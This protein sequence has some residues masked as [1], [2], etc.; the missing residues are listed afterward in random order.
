MY[1]TV[2]TGYQPPIG[3]RY[4]I[5]EELFIPE[6]SLY[7]SQK[8]T[9]SN[10]KSLQHLKS[11]VVTN[12]NYTDIL[13]NL[14]VTSFVLTGNSDKLNKPTTQNAPKGMQKST[15][16][17]KKW[18]LFGAYYVVN[19]NPE[20]YI[21]VSTPYGDQPLA[22]IRVRVARYFTAYE[23][24]TD[25]NGR[26]YFSNQF[27]Q[28]AIFPNIE[29]FVFFDGVNANNTWRLCD[30]IAGAAILWTTGIS[31]GVHSPD[32]YSMTF[33]TSSYFWGES[34]QHKALN[35]Y[36]NIARTDGISLPPASLEIATLVSDNYT[37]G[38][39]LF[40]NTVSVTSVLAIY[41]NL[42]GILPDIMLRYSNELSKYQ[43]ITYIAWHELTHAS[44]VQ[45]MI[46]NK[47]NDW[48]SGYW[49]VNAGQQAT[50]S[51][52]TGQPYG[53]KGDWNWQLIALSEG[54][55]NYREWVLS[56]KILNYNSLGYDNYGRP[57]YFYNYGFP[58]SYGEMYDNLQKIGCS[59]SN[60]EK[61]LTSYSISG[62]RDNLI[63]LYPSLN[64][65]ITSIIKSYE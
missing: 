28:D 60:M 3:I 6:H 13:K 46:N 49:S 42:Y 9:S 2:P 1:A 53:A 4:E 44:Q 36:M 39:P 38:T 17:T 61:S 58:V 45:S 7:Y 52:A 23:T 15:T 51:V 50:N 65:Q 56:N 27:G 34:V 20:G 8:E 12:A 11:N 33:N 25:A 40:K 19:F 14:E 64:T 31:I 35:D 43:M 5:I 16:S 62:Y 63:Q 48:A 54:W 29:Y 55:A 57:Y 18:G 24:R 47:G 30:N 37:S 10:I 26:F 41:N 22:N 32:N 21:K 59:Y